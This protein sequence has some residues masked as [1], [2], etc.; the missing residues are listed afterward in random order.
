MY[1]AKGIDNLSSSNWFNFGGVLGLCYSVF[2]VFDAVSKYSSLNRTLSYKSIFNNIKLQHL[3]PPP[4]IV[5]TN[6]IKRYF[7]DISDSRGIYYKI[8]SL[9]RV[10][11]YPYCLEHPIR[12]SSED[13]ISYPREITKQT[14][15]CGNKFDK[16]SVKKYTYEF[17]IKNNTELNEFNRILRV[18]IKPTYT[19]TRVLF[20][21]ISDFTPL[22]SLKINGVKRLNIGYSTNELI[23]RTVRHTRYPGLYTILGLSTTYWVSLWWWK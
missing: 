1:N 20:G 7:K 18:N 12:C 16:I 19:R 21:H 5:I 11:P 9:W 17:V 15:G 2:G 13:A 22:H 23:K 10:Y 3:S 8:Q 4:K 14:I 6:D